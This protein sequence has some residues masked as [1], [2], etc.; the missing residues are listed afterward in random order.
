MG[1]KQCLDYSDFNE[2]KYLD[3]FIKEV[4]R[5]HPIVSSVAR[6]TSPLGYTLCDKYIPRNT[7][8]HINIE[9]VQVGV[10][11]LNVLI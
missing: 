5:Y 4:L 9:C 1:D 2:L 8:V 3:N 11:F 7:T 10:K 6:E